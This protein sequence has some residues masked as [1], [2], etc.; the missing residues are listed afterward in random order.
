MLQHDVN[1][2]LDQNML[3]IESIRPAVNLGELTALMRPW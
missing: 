1:V 3:R 2:N